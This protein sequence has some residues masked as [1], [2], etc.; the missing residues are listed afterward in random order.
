MEP[1]GGLSTDFDLKRRDDNADRQTATREFAVFLTSLPVLLV[2]TVQSA[3]GSSD[4]VCPNGLSPNRST[5]TLPGRN[6]TIRP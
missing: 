1:G 4:A 3:D 5:L 6:W 2:L